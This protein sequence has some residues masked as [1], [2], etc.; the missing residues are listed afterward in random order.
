MT[1]GQRKEAKSIV[2]RYPEI[3]CKSYG[4]GAERKLYFFKVDDCSS[5][6]AATTA[7]GHASPSASPTAAPEISVR[8]TFI[9]VEEMGPVDERVVRSMPHGMFS[10]CWQEETMAQ[11][12]N[13]PT[14]RSPEAASLP[15]EEAPKDILPFG[16]EV[17]IE[18]LTKFPAF[19][20][21][22]GTVQSLDAETGRYNVL[23]AS[24]DGSA[25]QCAKIRGDNLRLPVPPPPQFESTACR[26]EESSPLVA[27]APSEIPIPCAAMPVMPQ[28]EHGTPVWQELHSH[29]MHY[30]QGMYDPYGYT[31][32][33]PAR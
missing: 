18:G 17:V 21:L 32:L 7:S 1:T 24:H 6:Q 11:A 22:R 23:L 13:G 2:D 3:K 5:P 28:A 8:N 30:D 15:P 4:C 31:M 12:T 26:P 16:S 14:A 27:P 20:G 19:N 25:E 9:H 33:Y 29:Q 10:K